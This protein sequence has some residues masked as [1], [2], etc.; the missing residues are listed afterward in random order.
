MYLASQALDR[1]SSSP[2]RLKQACP[3]PL[4]LLA[5]RRSS[6]QQPAGCL[7]T[8]TTAAPAA[9]KQQKVGPSWAGVS[10]YVQRRMQRSCLLVKIDLLAAWG[11]LGRM[12]ASGHCMTCTIS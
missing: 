11:M 6:L 8:Y 10:V 4:E 3:V 12:P 1:P 5:S 9:A 7:Q 2:D